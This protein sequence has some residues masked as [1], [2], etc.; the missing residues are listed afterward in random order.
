MTDIR[1]VIY[2]SVNDKLEALHLLNRF[3]TVDEV[4]KELTSTQ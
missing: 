1:V 3:I 4:K 2:G